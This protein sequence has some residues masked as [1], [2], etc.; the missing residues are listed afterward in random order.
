MANGLAVIIGVGAEQ[1]LGASLC[2]RAARDGHHVVVAGRTPAKI[3]ALAAGLRADGAEA[4]AVPVDVTQEDQVAGLFQATDRLDAPLA[5]VGYNAGNAFRH[6]TL[7]MPGQFFQDAWAVCCLGGFLSGRE[8]GRRMAE[9]GSGTI[10]FTGATASIKARPP[11]VAFASAKAG[12]RAAAAGLA[13]ELG[14]KG[15]HVAHAIIDGGIDGERLNSRA[16]DLKARM[17]QNGMLNPDAIA[18]SY[19]QVHLQHPSAW[20]FEIDLR[21][22]AETF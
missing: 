15:V 7:E 19:W 22:F 20:T 1:G 13:R 3:E 11:F 16:P 9:Q 18:E 2:R 5:F 12:L 8:A 21:P 14:P 4:T 17:G 6:Q 10:M